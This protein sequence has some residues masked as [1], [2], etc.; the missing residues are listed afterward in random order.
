MK[1]NHIA[2]T[3]WVTYFAIAVVIAVSLNL[4]RILELNGTL[5]NMLP[6][7]RIAVM[8][9]YYCSLPLILL[10]LREVRRLL[11]RLQND[12]VFTNENVRSL[13]VIR[14]C[15]IGIFAVCLAAGC[16]FLP[17]LLVAAVL[18]FLALMMQALKQVMAQAVA[19][20]EEN[21]LTV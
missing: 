18:G 20:Q 12:E 13:A 8:T 3:L 1:K 11:K 9:G 10:V 19:L 15:C 14:S 7:E 17:L 6:S 21:D 4:N 5:R 2:F 16:F